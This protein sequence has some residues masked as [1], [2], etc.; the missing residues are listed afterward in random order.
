M[1]YTSTW[2][3][4]G[5][6]SMT[7][8]KARRTLGKIAKIASALWNAHVINVPT[9]GSR[10]LLV[11]CPITASGHRAPTPT[12]H[13]RCFPSSS[14]PRCSQRRPLRISRLKKDELIQ[15]ARGFWKQKSKAAT[16]QQGTGG[17]S[18]TAGRTRTQSSLGYHEDHSRGWEQRGGHTA[19]ASRPREEHPRSPARVSVEIGRLST[20]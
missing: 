19:P 12:D 11:L 15:K 20:A 18:R 6:A 8:G 3:R 2:W 10:P 7:T 13:L 17:D 1:G 9:A 14:S 5:P 16:G 4:H